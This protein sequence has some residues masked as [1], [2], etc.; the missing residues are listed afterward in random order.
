MG[1][2]QFFKLSDRY[3]GVHFIN[4]LYTFI[5]HMLF[6]MNVI[7]YNFKAFFCCCS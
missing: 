7:F 2:V 4:I 5:L 6:Q 1:S 3:L